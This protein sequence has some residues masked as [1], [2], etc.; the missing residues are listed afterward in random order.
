[1]AYTLATFY[2]DCRASLTADPGEKGQEAVRAHLER[3]LK[4]PADLHARLGPA[5]SPGRHPLHVDPATGMH[6]FCHVYAKAGISK[7]H[8]HGPCWIIYGNVTGHTDMVEW[9]R[10]D[11]GR[12]A[13]V[14]RLT[15]T[16]RYRVGAG[17]AVLFKTGAIHET[18]HPDGASMLVRVISG[19]MDKVWRHTFD[20]A[21]GRVKDRPPR[22]EAD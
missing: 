14:A 9:K 16:R 22:P 4:A 12:E 2:D 17:Q 21:S 18:S 5:P 11:D 20:P 3:L 19:D 15:E 8:D 1:M 10:D 6:V 7:A 13:G